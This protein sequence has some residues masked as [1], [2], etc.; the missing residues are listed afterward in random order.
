MNIF[1]ILHPPWLLRSLLTPEHLSELIL[2]TLENPKF[3]KNWLMTFYKPSRGHG[4]QGF[5]QTDTEGFFSSFF[6]Y[7]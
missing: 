6:L 1:I 2:Y 7:S 3:L 4:G 5:I